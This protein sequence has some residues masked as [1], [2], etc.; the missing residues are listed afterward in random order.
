V[1]DVDSVEKEQAKEGAQRVEALLTKLSDR[2]ADVASSRL[3]NVIGLRK[4]ES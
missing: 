2:D 3:A 1:N 4:S